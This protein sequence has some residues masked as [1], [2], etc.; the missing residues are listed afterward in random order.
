MQTGKLPCL[1]GDGMGPRTETCVNWGGPIAKVVCLH[2]GNIYIQRKLWAW[3]EQECIPLVSAEP[4]LTCVGRQ[5]T[6]SHGGRYR[7]QNGSSRQLGWPYR[8]G[9]TFA[10]RHCLYQKKGTGMERTE[11]YFTRWYK[12]RTYPCEPANYPISW[13]GGIGPRTETC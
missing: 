8:H 1:L 2:Q 9:T 13:G 3:R 7:S 6:P 12:N 5:T 4:P 11:M 10:P